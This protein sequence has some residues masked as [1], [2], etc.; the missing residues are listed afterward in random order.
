VKRAS[1]VAKSSPGPQQDSQIPMLISF[2]ATSF[3]TAARRG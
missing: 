3:M 1:R 2:S